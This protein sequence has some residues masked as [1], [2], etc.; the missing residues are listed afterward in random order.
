MAE[1]DIRSALA[2]W[3]RDSGES[4]YKAS[5]KVPAERLQWHPKPEEWEGRDTEDQVAEC[6]VINAWGTKAFQSGSLPPI[7]WS[8][9]P[10]AVAEVKK[11]NALEALKT[12][13]EELASAIEAFPIDR[14][15]DKI[16]HPFHEG[17]ITWAD[18]A[19]I[20]Y[21]NDIYH[22]GQVNYIQVLYG[23]NS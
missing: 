16:K 6:A 11:G 19:M 17:E 10:A 7:D 15:G 20:F 14:L 4:L 2:S 23:D 18:F 9:Y 21:W 13:T 1:I 8:E 22:A 12:A 5:K 3:V